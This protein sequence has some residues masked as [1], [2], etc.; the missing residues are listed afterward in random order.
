MPVDHPV[1][2]AAELPVGEEEERGDA[3]EEVL[4]ENAESSVAAPL[5]VP[6]GNCPAEEDADAL[7]TPDTVPG[8]PVCEGAADAIAE[9]RAAAVPVALV[10]TVSPRNEGEPAVEALRVACAA[11]DADPSS[12]PVAEPGE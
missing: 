8:P 4:M 3:V 11:A 6:L 12:E 2:V 9:G 5:L 10:E 7:P 1:T